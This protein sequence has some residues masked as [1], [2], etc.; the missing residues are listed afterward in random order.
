MR[1]ADASVVETATRPRERPPAAARYEFWRNWRR[2][3][4]T[5][6]HFQL[7]NLVWPVTS[8]TLFYVCANRVMRW[9]AGRRREVEVIVDVSRPG[10]APGLDAVN[11]CTLCARHGLVAAGGFGGELVVAAAGA[12]REAGGGGATLPP[13]SGLR[14]THSENGITNAIDIYLPPG[15]GGPRLV[16]ANNDQ[17]VRLFDPGAGVAPAGEFR[18]PWAVNCAVAAPEGRLICAVGD[19][20]EGVLL[21]PRAG[22]GAAPAGVVARLRGHAD[23]SFAAAWHPDGHVVATGNQ[24]LTTRVFDLRAPAAPL[25]VLRA[26]IGAVRSLRFSPDGRTLAVAEPADYVTLYDVAAAPAYSSCQTVDVFG[27]LAG[28]G[29]S[30]DSQRFFAA[31]A[32]VHY[33]SLLQFNARPAGPLETW[34]RE[35]GGPPWP[36]VP[37][38]PERR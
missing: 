9:C 27:E 23:F 22:G 19:D 24:D 21:D 4:P 26:R 29:F 32:D 35:G 14:V 17:A 36:L 38:P 5:V 11:V 7:R 15:A 18:L 20:P 6:V 12:E 13:P 16:C 1:A 10:A 34:E 33:A 31:V 30:P 25:A 3:R 8:S 37:E 28:V 2:V